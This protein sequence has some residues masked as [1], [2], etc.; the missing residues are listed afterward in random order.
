VPILKDDR[1]VGAAVEDYA[2]AIYALE[3]RC[4]GVGV[5]A[6]HGRL[7]PL[8]HELWE[9][10]PHRAARQKPGEGHRQGADRSR[11]REPLG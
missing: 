8:H 7:R 9:R 11:R 3:G 6:V 1:P 2:K 5:G 4:E 10:L